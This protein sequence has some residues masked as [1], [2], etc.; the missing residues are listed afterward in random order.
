MVYIVTVEDDWEGSDIEAVFDT[1]E[2]AMAYIESIKQSY[3][4]QHIEEPIE[5][6]VDGFKC[7]GTSYTYRGW[8][9]K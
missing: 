3:Y 5:I 7:L 4:Y 1:T 9:V 6:I 2:K 8:K